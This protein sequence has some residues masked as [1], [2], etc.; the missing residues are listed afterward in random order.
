MH[1]NVCA[2]KPEKQSI[3][4]FCGEF[5]AG[6]VRCR[7]CAYSNA[8]GTTCHYGVGAAVKPEHFCG[9]GERR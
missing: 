1:Y 4:Y 7:E 8:N 3:A 5:I 9:Y 6:V 2:T